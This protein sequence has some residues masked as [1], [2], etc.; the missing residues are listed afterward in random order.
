MPRILISTYAALRAA[1]QALSG[2]FLKFSRLLGGK[3]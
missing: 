3:K 1:N 2:P